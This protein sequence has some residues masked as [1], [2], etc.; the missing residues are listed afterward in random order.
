MNKKLTPYQVGDN[1]VVAAYSKTEAA[2]LLNNYCGFDDDE[3]PIDEVTDLT[4]KLDVML[5]DEEG[6]DIETLGDWMKRIKE[7]E[8]LY[9]W[10]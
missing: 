3:T 6:N 10:E 5:N 8:Y 2:K 1:D 7:P 9:G 4:S